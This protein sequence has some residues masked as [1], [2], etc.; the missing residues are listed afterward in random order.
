MDSEK[1]MKNT[2]HDKSFNCFDKIYEYF[3]NNQPT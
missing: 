2:V 3:D 1:N